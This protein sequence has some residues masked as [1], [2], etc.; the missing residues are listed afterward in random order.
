MK[1]FNVYGSRLF[2][3]D[4]A[5]GGSPEDEVKI[6]VDV[7]K[8]LERLEYLEKEHKKLIESRDK[9]K[10][11]KRKQEEEKLLEEK[12]YQ[13]LLAQ[14]EKEL[15]GLRPEAEASRK[16]KEAEIVEAKTALG[17]EWDDE[18]SLLSIPTLRKLVKTKKTAIDVD[19]GGQRGDKNIILSESQK[20]EAKLMNLSEDDYIE[21]QKKRG[22][23]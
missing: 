13:E 23:L 14:K 9:A 15:Y 2:Q 10:E 11:E 1:T 5:E 18:Y 20:K 16:Y 4:G 21:V 7:T 19:K 6:E 8:K 17:D 22:K 12:K 3:A